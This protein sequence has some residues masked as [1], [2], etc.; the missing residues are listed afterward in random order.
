[1]NAIQLNPV[2]S[3]NEKHEYQY[4]RKKDHRLIPNAIQQMCVKTTI[5]VVIFDN[6][7]IPI[8]LDSERQKNPDTESDFVIQ[9]GTNRC[10][11][12]GIYVQ[13]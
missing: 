3:G 1:M 6:C 8:S 13:P 2:S 7:Y 10:I 4:R 11:N 9:V 5:S 12:K